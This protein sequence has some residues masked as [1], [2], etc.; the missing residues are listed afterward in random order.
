MTE[1]SLKHVEQL[2]DQLSFEEQLCLVE[3]L[4]QRLRQKTQ[5]KQPKD[6]YGIWKDRFPADFDIDA[7]LREI[8]SEWVKESQELEL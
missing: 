8:R 4:T 1:T 7:A 3:H 5:Q 6:L 2:V